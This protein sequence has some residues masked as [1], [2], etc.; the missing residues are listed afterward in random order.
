M[1]IKMSLRTKLSEEYKDIIIKDFLKKFNVNVLAVA[2]KISDKNK[3]QIIK[4]SL[5]PNL[6]V[7]LRNYEEEF[8]SNVIRKSFLN[9][10]KNNVFDLYLEQNSIS[11]LY[12]NFNV[13]VIYNL[14]DKYNDTYYLYNTNTKEAIKY[15]M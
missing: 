1:I 3:F 2:S 13:K 6:L 15:L 9:F 14:S 12:D 5:N 4:K 7:V 11:N 8:L 10:L